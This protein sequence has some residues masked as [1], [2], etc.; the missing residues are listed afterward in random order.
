[1]ELIS[2]VDSLMTINQGLG[3]SKDGNGVLHHDLA[4]KNVKGLI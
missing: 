4:L 3:S 1:M 2:M